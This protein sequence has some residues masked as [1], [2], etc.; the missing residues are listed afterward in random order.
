MAYWKTESR[1]D[2]HQS[3]LQRVKSGKEDEEEKR[4]VAVIGLVPN[5]IKNQEPFLDYSVAYSIEEHFQVSISSYRVVFMAPWPA[6]CSTKGP[7][8]CSL[9]AQKIWPTYR[10]LIRIFNQ[11]SCI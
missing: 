7:F 2:F 3:A 4:M 6:H 1:L 11:F 5:M 10:L 9:S 8:I